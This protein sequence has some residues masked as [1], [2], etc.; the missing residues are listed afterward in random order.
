MRVLLVEDDERLAGHV[1]GALRPRSF[2]VDVAGTLREADER[3]W[4]DPYDVVVFDRVL[5]DGD[6]L[7]L[8]RQMRERGDFTPVLVLTA[9]DRVADRVD[10]LDAGADDYLTKPFAM[11]ELLARLRA[12]ARRPPSSAPPVLRL[13]DLEVDPAAVRATRA[14]R[15][16]VLTS[17]EFSILEHLVRNTGRV[18]TRSELLDHCWDHLADPASNVVDVRIRLLRSKLGDPPLVHTVRGAGYVAAERP[19]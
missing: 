10:G 18:V 12:L 9:R 16:I 1:T 5:P 14:G 2:S 19:R 6:S 13:A 15:E 17:K 7:A 4:V 8:L 11:P 3:V